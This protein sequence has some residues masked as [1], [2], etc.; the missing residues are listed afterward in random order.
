MAIYG[1]AC[2]HGFIADDFAWIRHGR[3]DGADS[4]VRIFATPQ[5]F[6]RPLVSLSFGLDDAL[7]AD[8]PRGYGLTNLALVLGCGGLIV[9]LARR[10]G[11]GRTAAGT[12]A[13]IWLFNFHGVNMSV[14]WLSGRTSLLLTLF[15]LW[16]GVE[17]VARRDGRAALAALCAMLA[18]E[19]AVMLPLLFTMWGVVGTRWPRDTTQGMRQVS[20]RL[21]PMWAAL[22]VYLIARTAAGGI[23]IASAP[24]FYQ[25]VFA[26]GRVA[27]NLVHYADRAGTFTALTVIL[28]CL[29]TL[30]VPRLSRSLAPAAVMGACWVVAGLALTVFLPVRSSLYAL[31]PSVGFAIIGACCLQALDDTTSVRSQTVRRA[32]AVLVLCALIPIYQARSERWVELADLSATVIAQLRTYDGQSALVGDVIIVDDR[33]TRVSLQNAW[34]ALAP[35]VAPVVFNDRFRLRL[36]DPAQAYL[37][38]D[39]TATRFRLQGSTLVPD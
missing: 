6:Y 14:L 5:G 34:A 4:L 1:P 15:A 29:L 8:Q 2:G 11:L 22:V 18:K 3:L 9:L 28:W 25:P 32:I 16:A 36:V 35:D 13:L 24:A 23:S 20:D 38:A 27:E 30:Q 37:E 33:T 39:Q 26:V 21:L 17:F 10:L 7:F 31:F 12:A 19:E